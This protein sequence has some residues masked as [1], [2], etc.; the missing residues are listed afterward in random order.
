ML[1]FWQDFADVYIC[2]H[3]VPEKF[4]DFAWQV[5]SYQY[6]SDHFPILIDRALSTIP[7]LA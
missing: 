6:G 4:L 1:H 5:H 7:V 3:S 2:P